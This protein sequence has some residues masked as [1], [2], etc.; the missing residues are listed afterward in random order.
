MQFLVAAFYRV[1]RS[2]LFL[3]LAAFGP[4]LQAAPW[5][6]WVTTSDSTFVSSD[7]LLAN[8]WTLVYLY[9]GYW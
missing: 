6:A 2:A 4:S 8:E 1:A 7:S 9:R 5:P 3:A